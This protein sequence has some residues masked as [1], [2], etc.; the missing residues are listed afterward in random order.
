MLADS[1]NVSASF[2][3]DGIFL[4]SSLCFMAM[5]WWLVLPAVCVSLDMRMQIVMT[6]Q[7]LH[8]HLFRPLYQIFCIGRSL[9]LLSSA[10]HN[11][12]FWLLRLEQWLQNLPSQD[13]YSLRKA[14]VGRTHCPRDF[15]IQNMVIFH[16]EY[17]VPDVISLL[18]LYHLLPSDPLVLKKC[19]PHLCV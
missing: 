10:S 6:A 15:S 18:V 13:R 8:I 7:L 12:W 1:S 3:L 2:T 11:Y 19:V 17:C 14:T 9:P 5:C 16:V 4:S